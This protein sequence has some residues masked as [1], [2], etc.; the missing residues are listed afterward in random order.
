[1]KLILI[2]LLPVI[3]FNRHTTSVQQKSITINNR[4]YL[5]AWSDEFDG[6]QLNRAKWNY[7]AL[8]KRGDAY[9]S[10]SSI[11]L[12]GKGCLVIEVKKKGDSILAGMI[13]TERL[14]ETTYGYF[15]CR[16]KLTKVS[17]AW[18]GFWLQSSRNG[19]NGVPET[20][21]AEI[22][23]FEYFPNIKKDSVT[24]TLHW[25]GYG[26]TH[27]MAGPIWVPYQ[28]TGDGFHQF[29]L[30]WTP[31]GYTT[32]VDGAITY[33]GKTMVSKV[34]EFMVLSFEVNKLVAGPLQL[35]ALPDQFVVDHVRVYKL[36]N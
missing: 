9:N 3:L 15:E 10:T 32:F 14:F 21:G 1:M 25:G 31:E 29:A 19:D 24:H 30:E 26:R 16:A 22:D 2:A 20:H 7:R 35:A 23:I 33:S 6:T 34:P 36:K 11:W 18:P 13:D 5:L 17:G 12:D 8:G 28:R 27:K 4:E